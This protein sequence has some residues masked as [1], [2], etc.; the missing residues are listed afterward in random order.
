AE[1]V[2]GAD[3]EERRPLLP[4]GRDH[5][6][7]RARLAQRLEGERGWHHGAVVRVLPVL[8]A[9]R[10]QLPPADRLAR[11]PGVDLVDQVEAHRTETSITPSAT[12]LLPARPRGPR[13]GR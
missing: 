1:E 6:E 10:R 3:R 13:R 5:H 9:D 11:L 7:P 2:D 8:L 12:R 4:I